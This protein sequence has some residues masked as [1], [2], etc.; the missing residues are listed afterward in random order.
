MSR[1]KMRR[2]KKRLSDN[3]PKILVFSVFF[4]L[5]FIGTGYA[6]SNSILN[7]DG[8]AKIEKEESSCLLNISTSYYQR[9]RWG[10]NSGSTIYNIIIDITN[11]GDENIVGWEIKIKGPSDIN[12]WANADTS[13]DD[14]VATLID[15]SWN[16]TIEAGKT[17]SLDL[18]IITV[19]EVE[20]VDEI[21]DYIT[22]NGCT[23]YKNSNSSEEI[24]D[25][26]VTLKS[27]QINPSEY[28]MT[29]GETANLQITKQPSNASANLSWTS[30]DNSVVSVT[31]DGTIT[32]LATGTAIITVSSGDISST[33][34][35]TVSKLTSLSISPSEYTMIV[36]DTFALTATLKPANA[37]VT[38]N[39][40]S[41]DD[42]IVSVDDQGIITANAI[43]K[44]IITL[45]ADGIIAVSTINVVDEITEPDNGG[46]DINFSTSYDYDREIHFNISITNNTL[47]D[48]S[49]FSFYLNMPDGTTY[50]LWSNPGATIEDNKFT[51]NLWTVLSVGKKI[52]ITGQI[53]LPE[54]YSS[55][56]YLQA[57]ITDIDIE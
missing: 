25:S 41:N 1:I 53:K 47:S 3:K 40:S 31:N 57:E 46:L 27:L 24:P 4:L 11:N 9:A 23:V 12:V 30:S 21:L 10:D 16:G 26:T 37:D 51:F 35:I 36:G 20:T 15:L 2:L 39:W 33:C 42:N 49:K 32:A 17:L 19:E 56:D 43:G 13:I 18:S 44:A 54:G 7:I 6:I 14:G 38:L 8:I 45:Q 55:A 48:I 5:L 52:E 22:F 28:N 29:I 34:N 50:T